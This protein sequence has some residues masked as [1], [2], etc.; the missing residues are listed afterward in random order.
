MYVINYFLV[1]H[2]S[3]MLLEMILLGALARY[4][5]KRIVPEIATELPRIST[6]GGI[7]TT[8]TF[9]NNN[10]ICNNFNKTGNQERNAGNGVDNAGAEINE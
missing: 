5:Y 4:L 7:M 10:A 2:N 6:I 1:L 3:L 9:N 8:E